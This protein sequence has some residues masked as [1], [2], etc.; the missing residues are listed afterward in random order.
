MGQIF[1]KE[2]PAG[3]GC[4]AGKKGEGKL[5]YYYNHTKCPPRNGCGTVYIQIHLKKVKTNNEYCNGCYFEYINCESVIC[6]PNI[7]YKKV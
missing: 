1:L 2:L 4:N 3:I 5:C 6:G 7:I